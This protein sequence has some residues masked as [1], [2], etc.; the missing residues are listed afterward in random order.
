MKL[1]LIILIFF[2]FLKILYPNE[3]RKIEEYDIAYPNERFKIIELEIKI[4][5]IHTKKINS[6]LAITKKQEKKSWFKI[7]SFHYLPFIET[8]KCSI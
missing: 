4:K 2:I 5:D 1:I 3:V 8:E 6:I 7:L